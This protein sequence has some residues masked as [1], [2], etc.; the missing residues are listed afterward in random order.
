MSPSRCFLNFE[1]WHTDIVSTSL[2]QDITHYF[3]VSTP[4]QGMK[5]WRHVSG[6]KTQQPGEVTA[7]KF[8]IGHSLVHR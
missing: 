1:Y 6:P 8:G 5:L 4:L 7:S 3:S 2:V